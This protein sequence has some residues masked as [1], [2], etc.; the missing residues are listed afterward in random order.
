MKRN[1]KILLVDDSDAYSTIFKN[2]LRD[3]NVSTEKDWSNV[4][5]ET[6]CAYDIVFFDNILGLVTGEALA[7]KFKRCCSKVAVLSAATR[8]VFGGKYK[9]LEK[10]YDV[11]SADEMIAEMYQKT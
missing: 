6:M 9:T 3:H 2:I 4:N 7:K 1:L 8:T 5:C 10:P 11:Q